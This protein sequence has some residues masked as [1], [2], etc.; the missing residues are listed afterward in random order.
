MTADRRVNLFYD[1]LQLV[2]GQGEDGKLDLSGDGK[3]IVVE[4]GQDANGQNCI[5]VSEGQNYQVVYPDGRIE[6]PKDK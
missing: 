5:I 1:Y 4:V 3:K 2:E 6:S